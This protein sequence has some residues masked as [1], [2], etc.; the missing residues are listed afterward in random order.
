[1]GGI[2]VHLHYRTT[3]FSRTLFFFLTSFLF[4]SFSPTKT[5]SVDTI[6]ASQSLAAD[7]ILVSSNDVFKLGFFSLDNISWYL[8][9]WYKN[10]P[11]TTYVW[12][13]NRDTPLKNINS[14][15]SAVALR[16][17]DRGNHLVI[18]RD[19]GG[20]NSAAAPVLW[21]SNWTTAAN[22]TSPVAQLLDS[23]NLVIREAGNKQ[24]IFWQSFDFPTDTLLPDAKLGWDLKSGLNKYLTSWKSIT[25]PS[26]GDYTFKLN[27][28]GFPECFLES[29]EE[30]TYRSGPWNGIRF[31]GVPEM[32]STQRIDFTFM[33]NN[34]EVYYAYHV[35]NTRSLISRL[36]LNSTGSLQRMTWIEDTQ[37]W[38]LFWY[39]PK[40][41]CDSYRECGPYGICD[42]NSSPVCNCTLGFTPK[43]PQ[44][45]GL[46]EGSEGCVRQTALDCTTDGFLTMKGMKLP[47]STSA[48]VDKTMTL[49]ECHVACKSNCSCTAFSSANISN[50]AA[51]CV[52]WTDRLLVDMRHYVDGGQDMYVRLAASDLANYE[53]LAFA[54]D[55]EE[56]SPSLALVAGVSAV[57]GIL[58]LVLA[59]CFIW[60]RK[61]IRSMLGGQAQK[62]GTQERTQ[63]MLINEAVVSSNK[64]DHSCESSNNDELDLPLFHLN[65]IAQATN[66]FSDENKIGQGG[67]GCVYKGM[68]E[69][70]LEIAVKRLSK[71]SGQGMEEFKNEVRFIVRL[72]HVNLVRLLGCCIEMDEKIL[73]YEFMEH[74]SL[75]FIL[76]DK[77]RSSILNW[78]RRFDIICG[79]ARGLLYLHQDSRFRIIHRDLK[80]S[81][82]LLDG[83][84]CPKISDF[85][86][87]RMFSRDQVD[88]STRRVVGTYGYM[89]PEYAMDGLFSV[90]SDVFSF[91][92]LLLEIISGKKNRG[93]YSTNNELNLLSH[94]WNLWKEGNGMELLDPS[95][96]VS[97]SSQEVLRCIHVGLLC[98]QEHAEDRPVMSNVVLM[99]GSETTSMPHPRNP[100]FCLGRNNDTYSSSSMHDESCTVNQVTV[101]LLHGR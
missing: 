41:Q 22:P 93:F 7:Q 63:D 27:Y 101:T 12:V 36:T 40:D 52:M 85:G 29:R 84:M 18:V 50:G 5:S 35:N 30:V 66:N 71:N 34:H 8:G 51:G 48:Y 26:T 80:A 82:V 31:S 42:T 57:S 60:K 73:I 4:L 81:N 78:P 38:S 64:R 17:G 32:K 77:L 79:V 21:S 11:E 23:G 53:E 45:W 9:I 24:S 65:S 67:F 47:D 91:G 2:P 69:E 88:A 83:E 58:L 13:A 25:D 94:A 86:M 70:G 14:S 74:G 92:V 6:T 19:G 97:Y 54:D 62:K 1:M 98:V 76:F 16:I 96:G 55:S 28:R 99:L 59:A 72:Q 100:G 10:I 44:A 90:K 37:T 68:L 43:N 15:S 20:S 87:A 49:K 3:T 61:R 39:A 95:V 56:K 33:F 89:S 75:D 46:R